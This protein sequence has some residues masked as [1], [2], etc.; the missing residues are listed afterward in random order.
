[1]A[2]GQ[3]LDEGM[4]SDCLHRA[5]DLGLRRYLAPEVMFF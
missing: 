3:S 5:H 1:M 4:G 2:L